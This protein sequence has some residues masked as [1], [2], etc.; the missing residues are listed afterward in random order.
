[1]STRSS[2]ARLTSKKN[3][4]VK[5]K[6]VYHH[7][8]GHPTTLG[9]T[10]FDL[11]NGQFEGDTKA[12]LKYLIDEQPAG[13]STINGGSFDRINDR[14]FEITEKNAAGSGCEYA[15][16]FTKDGATMVVLSSYCENGAKMI[17]MFGMGDSAAEW[18]PIGVVDLNGEEPDW[19]EIESNQW[20]EKEEID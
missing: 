17:G 15:Y 18:K 5:F 14:A 6:G 13:W 16:A 1:M 19:G 8:D 4:P 12:M 10:L 20:E 7:W 3:K 11:R 2:I 9:E